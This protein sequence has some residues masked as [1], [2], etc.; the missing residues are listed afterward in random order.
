MRLAFPDLFTTERLIKTGAESSILTMCSMPGKTIICP[1][2]T[3]GN[4]LGTVA[5][6]L[7]GMKSIQTCHP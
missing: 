1:Y 4:E 2:S 6:P 3:R 5:A 7:F